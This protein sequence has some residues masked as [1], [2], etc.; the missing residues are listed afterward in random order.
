MTRRAQP[1]G[2]SEGT[3]KAS[4]TDSWQGRARHDTTVNR[5]YVYNSAK[6]IS[7]PSAFEV[8]PGWMCASA[9]HLHVLRSL[10]SGHGLY[11][12]ASGTVEWSKATFVRKLA[13]Q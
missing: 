2:G 5:S 13:S 10:M 7:I 8:V 3:G 6:V 11:H 12:P 9:C 4:N 1:L